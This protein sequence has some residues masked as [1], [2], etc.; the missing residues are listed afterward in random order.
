MTNQT[1]HEPA[2]RTTVCGIV[3]TV[4]GGLGVLLSFIP[5]VN[6]FAAI[7]GAVGVVLAVIALVGT[8]RGKKHGK[9]LAVVAAALSVLAIVI[10]LAMQ[11]ATVKAID[12]ALGTDSTSSQTQQD[13]ADSSDATDDA[14]A[15]ASA[16]EQDMEGDVDSGNYHVK[17][18]SL[19]KQGADYEGK[20]AAVLTFELT[21]NKTE[22]SNFM[23]YMVKAFQNG[24]ELES[25]IFMDAPEGYDAGSSMTELQPGATGTVTL[26]YVLEDDSPV[27]VEVDGTLDMSGAK[28]THVFDLQ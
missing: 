8:F 20:P 7:L 22:N 19:A 21:N 17:L 26:G 4:F 2:K 24:K 25:A 10:T 11:A 9:A 6:N 27:T 3:G 5:I 15:D 13:D 16:G 12:D 14:A 28:V 23:D 1:S 18:V